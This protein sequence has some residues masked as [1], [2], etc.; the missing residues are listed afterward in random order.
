M[1]MSH[2]LAETLQRAFQPVHFELENESHRH[3]S[4]AAADTHF[5]LVLVSSVFEGM[6][7]VDRHRRV[8]EAVAAERAQGLH[9]LT[10][11]VMTPSEWASVKNSF[12]MISPA[13]H[14][15][16]KSDQRS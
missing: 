4:G 16:S 9:A 7:R 3:A 1:S 13:C 10:M 15:G 11:R 14:G 5:K 6:T 8:M 2:A 12:Q